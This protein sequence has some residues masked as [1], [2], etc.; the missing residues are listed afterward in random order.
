L[1]QKRLEHD[2]LPYFKASEFARSSG[3]FDGWA[4]NEPRRRALSNDLMEI[5]HECGFR[6]F[7]SVLRPADFRQH[8]AQWQ[9]DG[10]PE[11]TSFAFAA[12]KAVEDFC[13][14]AKAE[15]IKRNVRFVF[16]RGDPEHEIR[17][18]FKHYGMHDPHFESDTP[19]VDRK[20]FE[21]DPFLGLQASDWLA[22]EYR[23]DALHFF[24]SKPTDRWALRQF[25]KLP[26]TVRLLGFGTPYPDVEGVTRIPTAG[27]NPLALRAIMES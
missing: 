8:I 12:M 23:L 15:G 22:Y 1:W 11:M 20:G 4:D 18:L 5:I 17:V 10:Y 3:P 19:F 21:Y 6:K 7:G 27:S 13:A 14:Y 16:D 24:E 9:K 25:D 2:D 26:G